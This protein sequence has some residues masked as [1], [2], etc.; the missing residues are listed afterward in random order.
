MV[1][2]D[3]LDS[4]PRVLDVSALVPH[5]ALRAYVMGERGGNNAEATPDEIA[6]MAAIV[7]EALEAGAMGFSTTRT[8]LHR[9]KDGEL[10]AGTTAS[11]A[12]LIG[13]AQAM[14]EAGSGTFEVASDMFDPDAEFAWMTEVSRTPGQRRTLEAAVHH[15]TRR[16]AEL[17]GLYDRGLL[18]PGY[19]ADCNIVDLDT[20]ALAAPEMVYDLPAGGRRLIQRATGYAATIKRGLVV[21]EDD[22]LT[23]ARPG[24]LVRGPQRS[25]SPR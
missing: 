14:G 24:R 1:C 2:L 12:E 13:I 22:E 5:G 8:I 7:R 21:R 18:A 20:L 4:M 15:Q 11:P 3:E 9:A 19:L 6:Q 17:Y 10:A 25:G 16:T 23:G